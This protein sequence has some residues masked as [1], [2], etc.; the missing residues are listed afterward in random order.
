MK[1]LIGIISIAFLTY[2]CT[3]RGNESGKSTKDK[4]VD[5]LLLLPDT[6]KNVLDS[7][8][9]LYVKPNSL[10]FFSLSNKEFKQFIHRTGRQSEWDFDLMYKQF[11]KLAEN[12]EEALKPEKINSFYSVNPNI[13]FITK[14]GDTLLFNREENDLFIGQI[15]FDGKDTLYIEEGLMRTD[16]L[17]NYIKRFFNLKE[18]INIK[19]AVI[20]IDN[21][22]V[23][24][25]DTLNVS[26]RDTLSA[27]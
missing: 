13:A 9:V 20:H 22:K 4:T 1:K 14:T 25:K 11:K 26:G 7:Q 3:F 6:D 23:I 2:S 10:V 5:S 27:P 15:F 18:D 17:E 8:S 12:T 16:S 21:Q 24:K 19:R